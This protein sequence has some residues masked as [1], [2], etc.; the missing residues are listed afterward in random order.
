METNE[1]RNYNE[2]T[3]NGIKPITKY[4]ERIISIKTEEDKDACLRYITINNNSL[5]LCHKY[6]NAEYIKSVIEYSDRFIYFSSQEKN[7]VAFALVKFNSK[8]KGKILNILLACTVP[9]E[10]KF[11]RMLA[12]SLYNFAVKFKYPFLYVSPRTPELRKTFIKYGFESIH[13]VEGI[14]EVLEK[15][16]DLDTPKLYKKGKTQKLKVKSSNNR[17]IFYRNEMTGGL[18][19]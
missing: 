6:Y 14:D 17:P 7:I 11:G 18:N 4:N 16:I 13:G 15:E 5:I 9:N 2:I 1:I 8:K 12:Y 3:E 19:E 10:N